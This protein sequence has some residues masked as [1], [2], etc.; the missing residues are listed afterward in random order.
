VKLWALTLIGSKS[1]YVERTADT[2]KE[3]AVGIK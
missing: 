1:V 2:P 3:E